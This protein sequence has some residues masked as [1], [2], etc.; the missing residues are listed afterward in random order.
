[1]SNTVGGHWANL[2]S[3]GCFLYLERGLGA[4]P[5]ACRAL[6]EQ[7]TEGLGLGPDTL[8]VSTK[9]RALQWSKFAWKK[10]DAALENRHL[11]VTFL[12]GEPSEAHL[13]ARIPITDKGVP[14]RT[15]D[16][17]PNVWLAAESIRWPEERFVAVARSW[18]RTAATHCQVLS[19]GVFAAANM[20]NAKVEASRE[21]EGLVG[22][23]PDATNQLIEKEPFA[24]H[25][26]E[27]VRRVY[28]ITLLGPKLAARTSAE[29]LRAAGAV[30]VESVGELLIFDATER[31]A[32][33]WNRPYL[34]A[35]KKLR[36]LVWP[37]SF[38]HPHDDPK[39]RGR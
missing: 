24:L 6:I 14:D 15:I 22:E 34:D 13:G 7:M 31:L 25:A 26:W 12:V 36:E 3:H 10:I 5:Q 37:W 21:F 30:A 32:E 1:M 18:F 2:P 8:K 38:Q 16:D 33:V 28:P 11:S 19:G 23:A 17:P 4:T 27:K 35:T 20:R 9:D 39:R 29:Q